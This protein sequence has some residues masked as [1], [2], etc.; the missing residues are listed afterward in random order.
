MSNVTVANVAVGNH[1]RVTL[2][3]GQYRD[4][5][6]KISHCQYRAPRKRRSLVLDLNTAEACKSQRDRR[7]IHWF[8]TRH[9]TSA[10]FTQQQTR[11][12]DMAWYGCWRPV[13]SSVPAGLRE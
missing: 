8:H 9:H 5:Q 13:A 10:T 11:S 4:R 2:P 3:R 7:I 6:D 1:E 12:T